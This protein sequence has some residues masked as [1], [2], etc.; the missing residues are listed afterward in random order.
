MS[1]RNGAHC[2]CVNVVPVFKCQT[3]HGLSATPECQ[4]DLEYSTRTV[5]GVNQAAKCRQGLELTLLLELLCLRSAV[6]GTQPSDSLHG[7]TINK[8][9]SSLRVW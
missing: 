8:N 2:L 1:V 4:Q 3:V 9:L 5:H 7:A 6:T